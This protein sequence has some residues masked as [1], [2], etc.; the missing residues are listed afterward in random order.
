MSLQVEA[1]VRAVILH[2]TKPLVLTLNGVLPSATATASVHDGEGVPALFAKLSPEPLH[3]ARKLS[4][5][6]HELG[7]DAWRVEGTFA[8]FANSERV[9]EANGAWIAPKALS[10][11]DARLAEL[12]LSPDDRVPWWRR[13]WLEEALDWADA[14]LAARGERRKQ[15]PAEFVRSWQ[16]S[17]MYRLTTTAG[18]RYLKAVP[19][20]FAREGRVTRFLHE[21]HP[22]AAPEVLAAR[23][24]TLFLMAGAGGRAF[25]KRDA[26]SVARLFARV[27]R[28]AESRRDDLRA[29][30]CGERPVADLA[31]EIEELLANEAL[32]R[33]GNALR[34]DEVAALRAARE[35]FLA[36]CARLAA[37]AIPTTLVHGDAHSGNVVMRGDAPTLL[38]WSDAAL[39]FP[40]LDFS[41]LYFLG[42]SSTPEERDEL[43]DAYLEA[44]T[45]VRPLE[46]LRA[47]HADAVVLGELYRAVSYVRFITPNVSDP[48]EWNTAHIWHLRQALQLSAPTPGAAGDKD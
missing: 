35:S 27:Q 31:L 1:H 10:P 11:E 8:L 37:S 23:S 28:L 21:L 32:L 43:R 14:A 7:P 22:H 13:G 24:D 44:W 41:P 9:D 19:D 47:L 42:T 33:A 4:Y 45:D 30:G 25:E 29:V 26:P 48:D 16:I 15:Q 2:P 6:E 38:D 12:A 46:E 36:A 39:S 18:T 5:Q 3:F 17:C 40:F 20:V 34:D